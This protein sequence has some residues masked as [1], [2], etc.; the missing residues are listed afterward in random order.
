[1]INR[2]PASSRRRPRTGLG[3]KSYLLSIASAIALLALA[4]GSD[5][6]D[7]PQPDEDGGTP[8]PTAFQL[9][10]RSPTELDLPIRIAVTLPLFEEFALEAGGENVEVISLIPA[11]ADPHTYEFT[12]ADIQRMKDIDFFFLNGAGL[13]SRLQDVIE[14]NRDENSHVIPFAPNMLSP[15]GD[16]RTA[17][18]AG[19]NPHLWLDPSLAFV[20][21]EIVDDELIIYDGIRQAFYDAKFNEFK[22]RMLG[23]QTD[24]YAQ[25]QALPPERRKLVTLH[26]SFDHFA[27]KLDLEVAGFAADTPTE[28]P[29]DAVDRLVTLVR[30]QGIP[31]VFAEYG[32][33][34]GLMGQ[35]AETTGVPMCTLYS[36]IADATLTYEE[37]M[38]SNADEIVRCLGS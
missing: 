9:P 33:D 37:T 25:L 13:D 11:G 30:D 15:L 35:V 36:D 16:G 20:Y 32:Y 4:C 38:R 12:A 27:R 10:Q 22:Q 18:Q 34:D 23:L 6:E 3:L 28:P 29:A 2:S 1:M 5:G 8:S 17:E 7:S 26:N 21:V 31:A 14:A 19:D 24:L